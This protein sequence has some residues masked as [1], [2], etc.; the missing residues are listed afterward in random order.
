MTKTILIIVRSGNPFVNRMW[1]RGV[2]RYAQ[3][4]NW[5]IETV[6]GL[7]GDVAGDEY[8]LLFRERPDEGWITVDTPCTVGGFLE[9]PGVVRTAQLSADVSASNTSAWASSLDRKPIAESRRILFTLVS[10]VQNPGIEYEDEKMKVL[11]RW[12]RQDLGRIARRAVAKTS[13]KVAPGAWKVCALNPDGS[14]KR[15]IAAQYADGALHFTADI[16]GDPQEAEF[17]Y[18]LVR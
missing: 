12:G 6:V 4:T 1:L 14:R 18:E 13:L 9:C 11:I 15:E 7:F 2:V 5:Q 10:D 8:S 3:A 16:A 17:Y